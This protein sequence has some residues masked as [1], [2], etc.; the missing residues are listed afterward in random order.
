[1]TNSSV[2]IN[3][4]DLISIHGKLTFLFWVRRLVGVLH[5]GFLRGLEDH[6]Q[7]RGRVLEPADE[8]VC[9]GDCLALF[10]DEFLE[11]DLH[12]VELVGN[13]M[14]LRKG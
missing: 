13:C 6:R 12:R 1:M 10:D 8:V 4:G 14:C 3:R 5:R 11:L 7:Q 9:Q 2:I